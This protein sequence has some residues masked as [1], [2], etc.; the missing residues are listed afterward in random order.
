MIKLVCLCVCDTGESKKCMYL[1]M[2][3]GTVR[4]YDNGGMEKC[5]IIW[6]VE[7]MSV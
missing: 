7:I 1:W 6:S 3:I 4:M 2:Q 5:M